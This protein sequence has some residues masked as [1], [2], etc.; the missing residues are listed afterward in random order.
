MRRG[1]LTFYIKGPRPGQQT[2]KEAREGA[3]SQTMW[4]GPREGQQM[5]K[6]EGEINSLAI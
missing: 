1:R 4:K 3:N 6:V 2:K 5:E